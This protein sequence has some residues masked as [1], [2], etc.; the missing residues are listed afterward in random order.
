MNE[1]Q[2]YKTEWDQLGEIDPLWAILSDPSKKFGKWDE[3]SFFKTGEEEIDGVLRLAAGLGYPRKFT[4]ALDFGCGVGRLARSMAQRFGEVKG[5]DVSESM[6]RKARDMN[7]NY[8]SCEFLVNDR[9]TLELFADNYFD[10]IYSNIVLQH[11]PDRRMV[12]GYIS[13]FLRTLIPGGL[14]VFQIPNSLPFL[15]RLQPR[16]T[17]FT[18]LRMIGVTERTLYWKFGLHP[19]RMI[20][21][22]R[23]VMETFL[24]EKSAE[25]LYV[26]TAHDQYFP[27][28]SS[29][30][31]LTKKT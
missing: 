30:Y 17:L 3:A 5:V 21:V 31:Y 22:P 1:L 9:D 14:I 16:R 18:V 15:V 27:V 6:I 12:F 24:A 11:L 10:F 26:E 4:R 13:E 25:I 19:I 8:Q 20:H 7:I 2:R 23:S 28:E 29:I